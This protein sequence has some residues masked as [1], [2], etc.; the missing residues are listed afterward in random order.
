MTWAMDEETPKQPTGYVVGSDLS[1]LSIEEL[2]ELLEVL[3]GEAQRVTQAL[4]EKKSSQAAADAF[5]KK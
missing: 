5:F 2:Q 4:A 1:N 3:S